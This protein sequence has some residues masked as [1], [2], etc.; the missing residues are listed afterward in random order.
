M[1]AFVREVEAGGYLG[2]PPGSTGVEAGTSP[3][4]I[5]GGVWVE[6][7]EL[8]QRFRA[9]EQGAAALHCWAPEAGPVST[10]ASQADARTP[11]NAFDRARSLFEQAVRQYRTGERALAYA[12]LGRII[13]VLCDLSVPA[14]VQAAPCATRAGADPY[15]TFL[16]ANFRTIGYEHPAVS[17]PRVALN[18]PS[19]DV[20][21][22]HDATNVAALVRSLAR[23]SAE[24]PVPAGGPAAALA[25]HQPRAIGHVAALYEAF[26]YAVRR[27]GSP[28]IPA[29][30]RLRRTGP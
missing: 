6:E 13:H 28:S 23:S 25:I 3:R 5:V 26:W 2:G 8:A 30:V 7:S 4:G 10:G 17:K 9:G 11:V 29:G 16:E 27:P 22:G 18:P 14:H 24:E 15:E 19:P 20:A 12:A 21:V 1:A